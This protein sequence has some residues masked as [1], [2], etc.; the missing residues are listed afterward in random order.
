MEK[1]LR[2]I[3]NSLSLR[4]KIGQTVQ[5]RLVLIDADTDEKL[6]EFF[7]RYPVGSIFA[8]PDVIS[9]F[10]TPDK[11]QSILTRCNSFCKVPLSVA[12]DLE[13]GG[14]K[15]QLPSQLALAA[16]GNLDY[17]YNF[18]RFCA[19]GGRA[20]G[21]TWTFSPEVDIAINWENPAMRMRIWKRITIL[22]SP[23]SI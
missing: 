1:F 14:G 12:G 2:R 3:L 11:P 23:M 21:F 10:S 5:T 13:H 20:A 7:T 4:E 9:R 19:L 15:V 18:G 16:T 17:A 8:G 22:P 6:E